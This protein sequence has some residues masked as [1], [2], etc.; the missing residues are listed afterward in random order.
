M[1]LTE[2]EVSQKA[3]DVYGEMNF[4]G[5]RELS[6]YAGNLESEFE[7]KNFE[8]TGL[9]IAELFDTDSEAQILQ[10]AEQI[11]GITNQLGLKL[12]IIG[13]EKSGVRPHG[14]I[15]DGKFDGDLKQRT[16]VYEKVIND[17]RLDPIKKSLNGL[18]VKFNRLIIRKKS[19]LLAST[20]PPLPLIQA[21]QNIKTV[22]QENGL[23]QSREKDPIFYVTLARFTEPPPRQSIPQYLSSLEE[24]QQQITLK[25]IN[26]R[27]VNPYIGPARELIP[28]QLRPPNF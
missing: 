7:I 11:E 25:P 5:K 18:D 15:I 16:L 20:Y 6:S 9:T 26:A 27:T 3:Q 12:A 8:G 13:L 17:Q 24:L 10:L 21:R 28:L 14:T 23:I 1:N 19:I 2:N 4:I 22:F